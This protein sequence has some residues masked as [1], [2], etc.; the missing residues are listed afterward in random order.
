MTRK[1]K[2]SK[3][4]NYL[5][6]N[7]KLAPTPVVKAERNTLSTVSREFGVPKSSLRKNVQSRISSTDKGSRRVLLGEK[8]GYKSRYS[9]GLRKRYVCFLFGLVI[10]P[11]PELLQSNFSENF[12]LKL[13][14]SELYVGDPSFV[15]K[16]SLNSF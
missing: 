10:K 13:H 1:Y 5:P 4:R 14:N 12:C 6:I 7:W 15:D 3:P 2:C 16:N 8:I 9:V 11:S